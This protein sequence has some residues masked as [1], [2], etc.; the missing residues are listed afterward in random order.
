MSCARKGQT[1]DE[2]IRVSKDERI[3]IE[4]LMHGIARGS[5]IIPRN[6]A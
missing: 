5:I 2:M 1:T 4:A 3:N 6:L